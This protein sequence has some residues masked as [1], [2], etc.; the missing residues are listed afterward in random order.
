MEAGMVWNK[1]GMLSL[2]SG[3]RFYTVRIGSVRSNHAAY[4]GSEI[5]SNCA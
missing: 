4:S 2:D 5:I 3:T 1:D